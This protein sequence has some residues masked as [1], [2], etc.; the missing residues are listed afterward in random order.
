MF[1]RRP[2]KNGR[3]GKRSAAGHF[4]SRKPNF[5][6]LEDR[7]M[8]SAAQIVA[9]NALPGTD[10]WEIGTASSN[11]HGY[12]AQFSVNR[13][14]RVD[15]KIDTY[16]DDYRIDIYR[17]GWYGGLGGRKVATIQPTNLD[18][19]PDP[20][21]HLST[22]TVDASN[23]HVS[24]SWQ[25]PTTAV[26]GVY[27]AKLVREDGPD[28]ENAII[29]VVRDDE[30]RSEMLFQTSDTSWQAY[31]TW[32]GVSLYG[33]ASSMGT[34]VSY[35][36]PFANYDANPLNF[37]FGEEFAMSRFLE[38]NGFDVSYTSGID[39]AR[40]GHEI[41]EHKVFISVGHDEYWSGEQRA[42]VEAARDAGVN[43][44]FFSGND[45]FWKT[46]WIADASGTPWTTIVSYKETHAN[47][48][49]D[50]LANVW[51]GTW[52][53]PR[54]AGSTDG[55]RPENA[56]T[57]TIFTVN[58]GGDLGT[59]IDVSGE[60]AALRFWRNTDV[61]DLSANQEISLGDRVLGYEFNEDLD[62]GFRPAGLI[63][64]SS[65]TRDVDQLIQDYGNEYAPGTATHALTLYRAASGAL[66]FS[67]GT[68]QYSWAL[69][70]YHTTYD[71]ATDR[72]LQQ[73]TINLFA[74]MGVQ[75]ASLMSGLVRATASTDSLAPVSVILSPVAGATVAAGSSMTVR[76][77]AQERGGGAVA[78]VEVSVDGGRSWHRAEGRTNWT[79]T[80]T[81]RSS[82]AFDILTRAVDD[83]GNIET[84]GPRVTVNPNQSA[85]TFSFWNNSTV[86]AV[87]DSQDRQSTELGVRFVADV[88][89][90]ITGLRF[91][92]SSA[93]TG[94]HV[95]SL[96]TN[97]GQLLARATFTNES[98]SGWQQV[99]FSTPVSITAGT[100]YVASYLAPNGGFSMDNNYFE[101]AG[102]NNGPLHAI[103][104]GPA[105]P[106]G[107]YKYSNSSAFPTNSFSN[108]NYWV[109]VVFNAAANS[110]NTPPTVQSFTAA[111]GSTSLTTDS[112][113]AI[114]LSE[115]INIATVN[116]SSVQL[117]NPDLTSLP[118][119]CCSTPGG[120]CSGCPL[121]QGANTRVISTTLSYDALS[122]TIIV[123]PNAPLD[124]L[125][126][127]TVLVMG[128]ANG[129][130]DLAGNPLANDTAATFL[131]PAQPASI[132]STLW[133]DTTVPAVAD[134]GDGQAVEVGVTFT[135]D[136]S[137]SITGLRF[138]KSAANTGTH[139]GNLWTS[140][141][142]LLA[143][144]TF[145]NETASGWQQVNFATPVAI[146]AG[147]TYVASYHTSSGHFSATANY[148][149]AA[150]D[151]GILNVP[152]SG[153]VY[154]YGS[155]GFPT[156][157]FQSTNYWVDVVLRTAPNTDGTAPTVAAFSPAA[158]TNN[159][160]VNSSATVRFSEAVDPASVTA[161][162]VKLT[163]GG[164]SLVPATLTYN[165]ST[166]TA[167]LTPTSPLAF[168]STYTIVVVGGAQGVKDLAG[169]PVAQTVG[170]SFT[171]V[172]APVSDTTPPTVV[173]VNPAMGTTNVSPTSSF[174]VTFSEDLN[175]ATVDPSRIL[176]LKNA[177]NRITT[178]VTYNAATRT[179]TIT[180]AA[181]LENATSYTIF[182]PGGSTGV[183]DLAGN[184]IVQDFTSSFMTAAPLTTSTLW[185]NSTTPATVD[186]G[187][188]QALEVG[189]K[190]T[191][192]T[193]GYITGVRFYK[194]AANTGTHIAH[195]WTNS[196]QLLATAYFTNETAS[197]WQQANF[198]T[199]VAITA[200]TTY[201]AS[202][203]APNGHFSVNRS[204][205]NAA[206]TSGAL[207]VPIGGG[208]FRYGNSAF[209]NESYQNSNYWVAPVLGIPA[210][211][212][213]TPPTVTSTSPANGTVNVA[214]SATVTVNFSEAMDPSTITNSTVK[215]LDGNTIVNSTVVYNSSNNSVTIT[216]VVA[217]ANS[218]NYTI[219]VVGG[220]P[221]VHDAA[222]NPLAQTFT[223]VFSTVPPAGTQDTTPPTVTSFSPSSGTANVAVNASITVTF[224]E[225]LTSS[226]VNTSTIRLLNGST[227][228]AATVAYNATNRTATITPSAALANSQTYT[229]SVTGGTNGVKDLAGNALAQTVTSTFTT[230]APADTT[231]PT[232]SSITPAGG[233][234]NVARTTAP[235]IVFSEAMNATTITGSTVRLLDGSTQVAATVTYNATTRTATIT[236]NATLSASR[237]Y[238]ISILGGSN[239][240]KDSAGNALAQTVTSSFTTASA[241]A[242]TSS[243]WTTSTTPATTD[244]GDSQSVELGVRFTANT[245]G[246]ITGIRFYKSAANTGTHIGSLWSSTGQRLATATF[247]NET[248]SGWQT[249]TFANPV[250]VTAGTTY[251]A[252]YFA[253][254]GRF[255]VNRNYFNS[256]FT[257]GPL[258]A[259][260][261]G[262]VYS[263]G[264]SSLF[265]SLSYQN[266]NYWVDVLFTAAN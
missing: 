239:G 21:Y 164:S 40:R 77:T 100:T 91:Y 24:A 167:T 127:Y 194:S 111:D 183:R 197:G 14:E 198:A 116:S 259:L 179:A 156:S 124:T 180:P 1:G 203:Y 190:F 61:E 25:V 64:L 10:D 72:N 152:A 23:W 63:N 37:Y 207:R 95:G 264:G 17:L 30:G 94:T 214:T 117:L 163:N 241:T 89:G 168:G 76:G 248:A 65:T 8:M 84:G 4:R 126:P 57:G 138:Y 62:N 139:I 133:P 22:D 172:A 120:W 166:L 256:A 106:N 221:G 44:T 153:G 191:S 176:L 88:N 157:T 227:S 233:A 59:T 103:P 174:T 82:G 234:T 36:R 131:T 71:A 263:Y 230:V 54:F 236:P 123:T 97:T 171:T 161:T 101:T 56:L 86:P 122:R 69:D 266:S 212:D 178:T 247:T 148:F 226:T 79:Y 83:S 53:D 43:L 217:L 13:G 182:L 70:D 41:L 2:K 104:S 257:N 160:P 223:S 251:V 134:S 170:S 204:Y 113:I 150:Y 11:I 258:T 74:D 173:S 145:T 60:F 246:Y 219:S 186:G 215:I 162:S 92:K 31:N 42:N 121:S 235:Q 125:Q 5:E 48:K 165:A 188:S 208:V 237:T 129:V 119:G 213:S 140:T 154:A 260:A 195:L 196:G 19:Q 169:N 181:A 110:D 118:G 114:K 245:N 33:F 142:Q 265:P 143:T 109:D 158:G 210:V 51:T 137:G 49:T 184:A 240:V 108:R 144:A 9:E 238:T 39:T 50:P 45:V 128:G 20:L 68:I 90:T 130:K 244:S 252:S 52:R 98:A 78:V 151:G 209:P 87:A 249:V 189:V 199:P 35:S 38:R 222:G 102:V 75:P 187:E 253:P 26:S 159:V 135:A 15:F 201:V 29:F 228:V 224:S 67:A 18:E 220:V 177:T 193:S 107:L 115:A 28:E 262:G 32:G 93:N 58:G 200:G 96:W 73:A 225:A 27:W 99:N 34:A 146:T 254:N 205:F 185:S 261:S 206:F 175:A 202:Y 216:P 66:V 7:W 112:A 16:A 242:S 46:R 250:A 105:G 55:G 231:A 155:G 243:L 211:A 136:K 218:K 229:I 80:F 192:T 3:R 47:A 232:I 149:T 85:S 255:A 141:G 132:R 81:V 147:T 12:A 6:S